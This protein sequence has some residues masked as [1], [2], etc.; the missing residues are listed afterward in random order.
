M[1]YIVIAML[2]CALAAAPAPAAAGI[3]SPPWAGQAGTTHEEWGFSTNANPPAAEAVSNAYGAPS[4]SIVLGPYNSGWYSGHFVF[5]SMQGFWDLG[6]AGTVTCQ[7]PN[8]PLPS[9]YTVVWVQTTYFVDI[10]AAPTVTVTGGTALTG[11]PQPVMVAEAM[12]GAWYTAVSKWRIAPSVP[13]VTVTITSSAAWGSLVD[14]VEIDTAMPIPGDANLDCVVN[15]LD[16][17][18][19]RSK[20]GQNPASGDNWSADANGDGRINIL[21]LIVTRSNLTKK[22]Q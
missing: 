11:I 22:C 5:G 21:D 15:I 13:S 10:S 19:I 12:S 9:G 3:F 17:L 6:S 18:F 20:L 1:R 8:R 7:I 2:L 16:L 4:A 14:N